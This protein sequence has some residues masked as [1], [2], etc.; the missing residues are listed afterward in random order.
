MEF[1]FQKSA[2]DSLKMF[3]KNDLHSVIISGISGSGKTYLSKQYA[4]MLNISDFSLIQPS[5]SNAR[6]IVEGSIELDNKVLFCIENLD[7]GVLSTS[8]AL[9]KFIEEPR[10]NVY[11]VVTCRN[12]NMIPDTI[13]SRSSHIA[14]APPMIEDINTYAEYKD[15]LRFQKIKDTKLW[16]CAKTF[17]DVDKLFNLNESQF[18]YIDSINDK[19]N[20]SSPISS[21]IWSLGHSDDGSDIPIEFIIDRIIL[22]NPE[23]LR[24]GIRCMDSVKKGRISSYAILS[25]FIFDVKYLVKKG[26]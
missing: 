3:A 20:L 10:N 8:Y 7:V 26:S 22:D 16:V 19:I 5:V 15:P 11:I 14:L 1:N 18:N 13:L 9:L 23:Y 2:I 25:K 12:I 24:Y 6:D 17:S 4:N 21:I